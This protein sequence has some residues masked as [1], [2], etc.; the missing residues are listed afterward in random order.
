MGHNDQPTYRAVIQT[1]VGR[2][3]IVTGAGRVRAID[4]VADVL[5]LK[6]GRDDLTREVVRQLRAYFEDP[7]WVFTLP[8][9]VQGTAHRRRVWDAL[10]RI[11]SGQ[12]RRYGQLAA[13]LGSSARAVGGACRANPLPVIIPCHRVVAA[14]GIGGFGG[15]TEG[16][17]VARKRWLLA[18]EAAHVPG[19]A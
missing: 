15:H 14:S 16:P 3:G 18:H 19:P 2:L 7:A 6:V 5:A 9:C 12:T 10:R 1:P 8:L 11:P 4:F 13:G 17:E